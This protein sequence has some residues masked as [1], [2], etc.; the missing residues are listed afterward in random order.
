MTERDLQDNI[1]ICVAREREWGL[2]GVLSP[3]KLF[4]NKWKKHKLAN[5]IFLVK[6]LATTRSLLRL[7]PW[8]YDRS[9]H[10]YISTTLRYTK[11]GNNSVT[12]LC[13]TDSFDVFNQMYFKSRVSI[14]MVGIRCMFPAFITKFPIWVLS[15]YP[16]FRGFPVGKARTRT[17]GV[18]NRNPTVAHKT[19]TTVYL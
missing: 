1:Y 17:H 15:S 11:F 19:T 7:Y 8:Q 6:A 3:P 10:R 4:K 16:G 18:P 14:R 13:I 12:V 9:K 2:R 5:K